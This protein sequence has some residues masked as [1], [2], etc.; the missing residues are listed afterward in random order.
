MELYFSSIDELLERE[1]MP[2]EYQD[3]RS[4]IYCSDCER[5]STTNYHFVYHKVCRGQVFGPITQT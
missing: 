5:K 4:L 2:L 3:I 1:Q